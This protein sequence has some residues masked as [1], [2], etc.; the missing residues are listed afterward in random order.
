MPSWRDT[1]SPQCQADLDGLLGHTLGVAQQTLERYGQ[2]S[3]F[4]AAVG[5][6][7][8][9]RM[10]ASDP[11]GNPTSQQVLDLLI[12]GA[13]SDK[14]SLRAVAIVADVS[15]SDGDAVRVELE[16]REGQTMVVVSTCRPTIG[17]S[18]RTLASWHGRATHLVVAPVQV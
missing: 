10:L 13:R 12:D 14:E 3:P 5:A 18:V 6:N 15:L 17:H 7:G 4:G 2:L 11:G 9:T 16:H 8:S 1:A